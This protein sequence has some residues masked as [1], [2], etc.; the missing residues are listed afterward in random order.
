[1]RALVADDQTLVRQS[2]RALLEQQAGVTVVAEAASGREALAQVKTHQPDLVILDLRLPELNGIETALRLRAAASPPHVII[3]STQLDSRSVRQAR[4]AGAAGIVARSQ[5]FD[6]LA[7]LLRNL[8]NPLLVKT[9]AGAADGWCDAAS[10]PETGYP[11]LSSREREV[12]QL[13]AEGYAAKEI[14]ADLGVS[15]KTVDAHRR[16]VMTKLD[17][18]SVPELTRIAIREGLI[19]SPVADA[20]AWP[21]ANG[22]QPKPV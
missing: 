17:V 7:A 5:S 20:P 9:R 18:G 13:L 3:V 2:L 6:D 21:S 15:A 12:L 16:R 8:G 10:G 14:A 4:E 19:D 22:F 11:S 1:M